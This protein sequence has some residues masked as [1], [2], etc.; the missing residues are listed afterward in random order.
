[1]F[2]AAQMNGGVMARVMGKE[3]SWTVA[4]HARLWEEEIIDFG[5][6]LGRVAFRCLVFGME[7]RAE[8]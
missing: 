2:C 4:F 7:G 1:M 6:G 3:A 8:I 5:H